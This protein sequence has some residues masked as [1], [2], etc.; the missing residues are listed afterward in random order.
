MGSGDDLAFLES[1]GQH[2]GGE[3]CSTLD[4]IKRLEPPNFSPETIH[5]MATIVQADRQRKE[6][7][8]IRRGEALIA[9]VSKLGDIEEA[10]NKL[11]PRFVPDKPEPRIL[12]GSK[13]VGV[14]KKVIT[15]LVRPLSRSI[16]TSSTAS[17]RSGNSSPSNSTSGSTKTK[18]TKQQV[19]LERERTQAEIEVEQLK[20]ERVELEKNLLTVTKKL[21]RKYERQV[22]PGVHDKS[23]RTFEALHKQWSEPSLSEAAKYAAYMD[24]RYATRNELEY[25]PKPSDPRDATNS[26][27][28]IHRQ[29][30][31]YGDSLAFAKHSLRD[32]F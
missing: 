27:H 25:F 13:L 15:S 21:Y 32:N 14:E 8:R 20:G 26:F 22:F 24:G 10:R 19:K 1:I 18:P 3:G 6:L 11:R 4:L 16:S 12:R 23:R 29:H 30:T 31:K 2:G 9:D 5:E 28:R 7:Q 17:L